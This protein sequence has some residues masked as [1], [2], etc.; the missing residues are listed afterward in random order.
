VVASP[1][2][3]PIQNSCRNEPASCPLASG[4]VRTPVHEQRY[5]GSDRLSDQLIAEDLKG[6]ASDQ[7]RANKVFRLSG[8]RDLNSRPLDPQSSAT[9]PARFALVRLPWSGPGLYVG[10]RWRKSL[11]APQ[12]LQSLLQ[13]PQKGDTPKIN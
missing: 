13:R 9:R 10:E 8:W 12:L 3:E 6:L 5:G 4:G 2:P 7:S 1:H 11:N